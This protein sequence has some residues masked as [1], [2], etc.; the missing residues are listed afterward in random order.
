MV[1]EQEGGI[2]FYMRLEIIN[3]KCM[4]VGRDPATLDS[5][6]MTNVYI[7]HV[8]HANIRFHSLALCQGGYRRNRSPSV[9]D[10]LPTRYSLLGNL[11]TPYHSM[12]WQGQDK[13][14]TPTI[15]SR[16]LK[17]VAINGGADADV[18]VHLSAVM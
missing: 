13:D 4:G 10:T 8:R 6:F 1:A 18:C 3:E 12:R 9:Q 11:K 16:T 14:R 15:L 17:K 7:Y 5:C 2:L